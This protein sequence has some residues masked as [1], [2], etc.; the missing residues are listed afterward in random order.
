MREGQAVGRSPSIDP[1]NHAPDSD[2]RRGGPK[3]IH[4]CRQCVLVQA[5][6][7]G[8]KIGELELDF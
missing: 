1:G 8:R 4:K 3:C 6:R 2:I 7:V 5:G